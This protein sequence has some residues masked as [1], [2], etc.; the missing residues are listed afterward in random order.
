MSQRQSRQKSQ[1]A[2]ARSSARRAKATRQA[3]YRAR[4]AR[5]EFLA[6]VPVDAAILG[7]LTRHRWLDERDAHDAKKVAEAIVD[8][9]KL[10]AKI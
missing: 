5:G 6:P 3:A 10:S 7:F 9:L 2:T 8:L 1:P 4:Q